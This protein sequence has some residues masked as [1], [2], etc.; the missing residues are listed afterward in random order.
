[1]NEELNGFEES[2]NEEQVDELDGE[3][4][5]AEI[6]KEE[7]LG[8]IKLKVDVNDIV[9]KPKRKTKKK[10]KVDSNDIQLMTD[11]EAYES[12]PDD[13]KELY[14]E[15]Y[16]FLEKTIDL[17]L[18]AGV[19]D[20]IPTGIDLVDAVL[21]GGF[22]SGVLNIVVGPPGSGKSMLVGQTIGCGQE[23]YNGLIMTAYLDS[24]YSMSSA[25]LANLG[26][27]KPKIRPHVG[28]TVETLFQFLESVCTFK[29]KRKDDSP[30][31]IAWDSIANTLSKK[32]LE[33]EDINKVVG[34]RSRLYSFLIPK[35]A[36]KLSQ[37]NVCLLAVNQLRDIIAIN[38]YNKPSNDLKNM[39][40]NQNMPGGKT[41]KFNAFQLVEVKQKSFP[42]ELVKKTGF[43]GVLSGVKCIKNKLYPSNIEVEILGGLNHGFSNFWTNYK[44]LIDKKRLEYGGPYHNL[45]NYPTKKY[46]V[47]D[48]QNLYATDM[49]FQTAFKELVRDTI[50][51]EILQPNEL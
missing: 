13:V 36:M 14:D 1:M 47:K 23:K 16:S 21:G 33:A 45:I 38:Q 15:F 31:I 35:Y 18:D 19:K 37:Y 6:N 2:N 49:D 7:V 46:F 11:D 20:I 8:D 50:Y 25:R 43:K 5:E 44:F 32:E 4:V 51:K 28:V 17:K 24:E 34:Y 10:S 26:V 27:I 48:V 9:V 42:D 3:Y 40:Q 12:S 39:N 30:A 29:D 22:A 41:I